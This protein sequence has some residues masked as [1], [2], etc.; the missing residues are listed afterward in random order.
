M[1]VAAN[2]SVSSSPVATERSSRRTT[3]RRRRGCGR[4]AEPTARATSARADPAPPRSRE[5]QR[6]PGR[7]ATRDE[8]RQGDRRETARRDTVAC[9]RTRQ[10]RN[11]ASHCV[12]MSHS[13]TPRASR[14]TTRRRE[15][16]R[17]GLLDFP[18]LDREPGPSRPAALEPAGRGSSGLDVCRAACSSPSLRSPACRSSRGCSSRAFCLHVHGV[19]SDDEWLAG[20]LA[21]H[22]STGLTDASL[23]GLDHGRRRRAADRRGVR[24]RDRRARA[25][26][27]GSPRSSP[28]RSAVESGSYRATTLVVHRHRP[29]GAPPREAAGERELPVGPHRRVDRRLLRHRAP[30]HLAASR[31]RAPVSPSGRSRCS[32]RSSSRSP[33]CTAACTTRS[34]CS[35][36]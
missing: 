36:A 26:T 8:L 10:T 27:G 23:V 19:A 20:F 30:A 6:A 4:T 22:R 18:V 13:S 24:C 17:R 34:T 12:G 1:S 31:T 16:S 21:R 32:S 25:G 3:S 7:R 14:R 5:Y 11:G 35:A 33:G 2:A 15:A 28:A 9:F 29:H